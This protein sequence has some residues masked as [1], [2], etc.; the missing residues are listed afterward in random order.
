MS[1]GNQTVK[2][3]TVTETGAPGYLGKKAEARTEVEVAG[4]HFRPASVTETPDAETDVATEVWKLTAPPVAAVLNA[5]STDEL[6]YAGETFQIDG[7]IMP[8]YD[9]GALHHVT[10]MCKKQVG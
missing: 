7:P 3:V 8:K 2:I 4:C 9:L 10:V 6:I 1:F 5:K